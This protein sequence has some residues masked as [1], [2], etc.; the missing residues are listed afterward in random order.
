MARTEIIRA[1]VSVEEKAAVE[2]QAAKQGRD[3]SNLIRLCLRPVIEAD[4]REQ[5]ARRAT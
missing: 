2:R 4:Q 1:R 5:T 3:V